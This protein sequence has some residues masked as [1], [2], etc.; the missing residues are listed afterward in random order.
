[1]TEAV[2]EYDDLD[3]YLDDGGKPEKEAEKKTEEEQKHG[4]QQQ[5]RK[6]GK[7]GAEQ[8]G[9][10]DAEVAEMIN[11]L[12]TQFQQMLRPETDGADKD[13]V[14]NFRQLLETLGQAAPEAAGAGAADAGAAGKE[15]GQ[16]SEDF[17]DIISNALGRLKVNSSKIDSKLEQEK[18]AQTSDDLLSQLLEQMAGVDEGDGDGTMDGAILNILNQMSSKEVMYQP[19]K[20]MQLEFVQWMQGNAELEEHREKIATY[21]QQLDTVNAIVALY[22]RADYSNE[23]YRGE[24]TDL[25]D[26]LE[27]LG[28]SPV[29][30]GFSNEGNQELNDLAKMLEVDGDDPSLGNIDKE[31]QETCKQQ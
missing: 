4:E 14:D 22:E 28:D 20:E 27:Q 17:K 10:T 19:M 2:D 21:R 29:N 11:D 16:G 25:I 18:K 30:K 1:M 5:T 12:Q 6:S 24:I 8:T 23:K 13:T 15:S 7:F 9:G 3:A 31:I 26:K